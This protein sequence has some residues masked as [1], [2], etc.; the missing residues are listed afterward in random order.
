MLEDMR[1]I[2]NIE[3]SI[4][5]RDAFPQIMCTDS[6]RHREQVQILPVGMKSTAATKVKGFHGHLPPARKRSISGLPGS[7]AVLW[8]LKGP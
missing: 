1:V 6:E 8:M 5:V 4:R 7:V 3:T 2:D